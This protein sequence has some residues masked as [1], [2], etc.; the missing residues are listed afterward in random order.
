MTLLINLCMRKQ[1]YLY[2]PYL[3]CNSVS[4]QCIVMQGTQTLRNGEKNICIYW[5]LQVAGLIYIAGFINLNCEFCKINIQNKS[6]QT[7]NLMPGI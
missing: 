7:C 2:R 3:T 1:I 5:N 4:T 6:L